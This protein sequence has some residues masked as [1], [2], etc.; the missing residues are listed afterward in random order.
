S[1]GMINPTFAIF[2]APADPT[3]GNQATCG[4]AA[5]RNGLAVYERGTANPI[6]VMAVR[7]PLAGWTHVA[8]VYRDGAPSLYVAGKLVGESPRSG[9]TVRPVLWESKDAPMDF[10]GQMTVPELILEP[11]DAAKVQQLAAASLPAPEE[12]AACE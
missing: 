1:S 2:P 6:P 3:G 11:V 10:M 5:G 12:P 7:M 4:L 9:K 8:L